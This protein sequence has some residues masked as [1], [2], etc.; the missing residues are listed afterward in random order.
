MLIAIAVFLFLIIGLG[1]A[2]AITPEGDRRRADAKKSSRLK[3]LDD[4]KLASALIA[5]LRERGW[6]ERASPTDDKAPKEHHLC[7]GALTLCI[8]DERPL[9]LELQQRLIG[10]LPEHFQLSANPETARLRVALKHGLETWDVPS[11]EAFALL[12]VA[13][14][15]LHR[16]RWRRLNLTDERLTLLSAHSSITGEEIEALVALMQLVAQT[17]KELNALSASQLAYR[18]LQQ[19]EAQAAWTLCLRILLVQPLGELEQPLKRW[20][21]AHYKDIQLNALF[22]AHPDVLLDALPLDAL[23][24]LRL[25]SSPKLARALFERAQPEAV[26]A[27]PKLEDGLRVELCRLAIRRLSPSQANAALAVAIEAAP[28]RALSDLFA[29]LLPLIEDNSLWLNPPCSAAIRSRLKELRAPENEQVFHRFKDQHATTIILTHYAALL[30]DPH[31]QGCVPDAALMFLLL[32]PG[33]RPDDR[34]LRTVAKRLREAYD[35]GA[36]SMAE[37]WV[38]W[39]SRTDWSVDAFEL[40]RLTVHA[41]HQQP[42]AADRALLRHELPSLLQDVRIGQE[43]R[44]RPELIDLLMLATHEADSA[45]DQARFVGAVLHHFEQ[46]AP[47]RQAVRWLSHVL[48]QPHLTPALQA[49]LQKLQRRFIEEL[50]LRYEPGA[51]MLVTHLGPQGALT[52]SQDCFTKT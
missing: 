49:Q 34:T 4:A 25:P 22:E 9:A 3:L 23:F 33:W 35:R 19:P 21:N 13:F 2:L 29:R 31:A 6:V 37:C 32:W 15:P 38:L 39:L 1:V 24:K 40:I 7:L 48:R 20:I 44:D 47:E 46:R 41:P 8:R 50:G 12:G 16:Q 30:R 42:S 5:Q 10:A 14:E 45:K 36:V 52:Q 11:L 28:Q 17:C 27:D 51:M 43:Q 18:R 26:L